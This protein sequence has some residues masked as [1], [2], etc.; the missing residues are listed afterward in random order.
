MTRRSKKG[1]AMGMAIETAYN[2]YKAPTV[3]P[4][5]TKSGLNVDPTD[6]DLDICDGV[7]GSKYMYR[8][9]AEVGGTTE[10]PA[11]P[12]GALE[13]ILKLVFGSATSTI[14]GTGPGYR[15]VFTQDWDAILS[16][17]LTQWIPGFSGSEEVEA[18]TGAVISSLEIGYD[19]PGPITLKVTWDC[20]G[21]DAAQSAPTRSYTTA[22]PFVW[23]N[24][25]AEIDQVL[26][27]DVTK[28]S[29]K[30]DRAVDKLYGATGDTKTALLPNIM[31]PTDWLVTGS[32]QFPK[33]NRDY[34]MEYLSG[35]SSGTTLD[36]IIAEKELQLTCTGATIE[37]TNKYLM[38]FKMPLV[39]MS[40]CSND[41]DS[42]K[43]ILYDID[44]AARYFNGVDA[45]LGTNCI[46]GGEV[47]SK[48]V[49]IT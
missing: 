30:I 42:D 47:V 44:Y 2:T 21:F 39:N 19:G 23:G 25:T 24:F 45:G 3:Y 33:E 49:S 48:L 36:T 15:H 17:S 29:L 9:Q 41:K 14:I 5:Y 46:L 7:P 1:Y 27:T 38:D 6:E 12:E 31:T 28:A 43:A 20:G 26:K 40:K 13:Q 11:W 8:K 32:L 34:L 4:R 35:S 10:L 18:F 37:T 16:A 22:A